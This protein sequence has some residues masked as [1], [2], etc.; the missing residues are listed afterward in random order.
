MQILVGWVQADIHPEIVSGQPP[1]TGFTV[2]GVDASRVAQAAG[3][4][5]KGDQQ[6]G[7]VVADAVEHPHRIQH[8]EGIAGEAVHGLP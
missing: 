8:E 7:D 6:M 2:Q 3:L 5:D 1:Q 4:G